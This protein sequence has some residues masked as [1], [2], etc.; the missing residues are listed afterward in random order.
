MAGLPILPLNLPGLLGLE[1]EIIGRAHTEYKPTVG[2]SASIGFDV[3]ISPKVTF[4]S[5]VRVQAYT[6]TLRET[7]LMSSNK[8]QK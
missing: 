3:K 4:Y 2:V 6:I 1:I 5:E 7:I 8:H